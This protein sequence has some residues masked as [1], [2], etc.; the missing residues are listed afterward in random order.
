MHIAASLTSIFL[1]R[2][3][4]NIQTQLDAVVQDWEENDYFVIGLQV[5]S[6]FA[7]ANAFAKFADCADQLSVVIN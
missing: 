1:G 4:S 6:A 7:G 2:V 5:R 3:T